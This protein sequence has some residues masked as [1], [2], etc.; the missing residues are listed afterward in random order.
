MDRPFHPSDWVDV[1]LEVPSTPRAASVL[2]NL[3]VDTN[4]YP[5]TTPTSSCKLAIYRYLVLQPV[6]LTRTRSFRHAGRQTWRNALAFISLAFSESLFFCLLNREKGVGPARWEHVRQI[7]DN[8]PIVGTGSNLKDVTPIPP[9][10]RRKRNKGR[11]LPPK[12]DEVGTENSSNGLETGNEP[13]YSSVRS[14]KSSG[15][16][17]EAEEKT[18]SYE[19]GG[20]CEGKRAKEIYEH[21]A[22]IRPLHCKFDIPREYSAGKSVKQISTRRPNKILFQEFP[23]AKI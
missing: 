18:R 12:P 13:L 14:P 9:P 8:L 15:D 21:K 20:G 2:T 23:S 4:L 3:T 7:I 17:Q 10:R 22:S 6:S 5:A 11:P 16:E 19:E 1:N